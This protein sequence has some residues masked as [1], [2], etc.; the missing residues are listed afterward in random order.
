M[1]KVFISYYHA[2]DQKY[3]DKLVSLAEKEQ[4]FIDGS[5][6]TG[7]IDDEGMSDEAIRVK[8]RDEY[9]RETSVTIVLVGPETKTRKHVDWEIYS[10]MYN[11]KKNKKSGI[12][13]IYLPSVQDTGHVHIGHGQK[14][15]E[16]VHPTISNW[17]S[18]NSRAEYEKRHPHLPD[19]IID[20]LLVNDSH[21]SIL[22]WQDLTVE[23]LKN[24]IDYAYEDRLNSK[25]DL[26]RPM[27]R[28]N[29]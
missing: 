13:V 25:Y 27:R 8:I 6:D 14:E 10:S 3:K 1:H 2:A 18:V 26:S 9:L 29:G 17:V 24:L 5:V 23:G 4:I 15:K 16:L 22:K 19:R 12:I 11:G 20:N 7:D 21:I 28:R